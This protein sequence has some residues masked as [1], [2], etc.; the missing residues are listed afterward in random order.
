MVKPK[1]FPLKSNTP[2]FSRPTPGGTV[3]FPIVLLA[4]IC[5]GNSRSQDLTPGYFLDSLQSE[6]QIIEKNINRLAPPEYFERQETLRSFQRRGYAEVLHSVC[7]LDG[8]SAVLA[9][10]KMKLQIEYSL[11]HAPVG[12]ATLTGEWIELPIDWRFPA[13]PWKRP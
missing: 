6:S 7:R 10:V 8:L 1:G 5:A 4:L 13:D 11:E 2:T 12:F 3:A 9:Y